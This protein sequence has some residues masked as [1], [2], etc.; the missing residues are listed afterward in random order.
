M[1][2]HTP[3]ARTLLALS[4]TAL[5][6]AIAGCAGGPSRSG[7]AAR[8]ADGFG[9]QARVAVLL[10]ES[11]RFAG[12]AEAVKAGILAAHGVGRQGARPE[13]R[14]YDSS[15]PAAVPGLLRQA[16][17]DGATFAIGPLQKDSVA[18]LAE[19]GT[20]PIPTL[21]LNRANVASLPP[22]LY[23][24]ALS[25][26][27]E[28]EE[29]ANSAWQQGLR[30]ALMLH[31]SGSWGERIASAFRQR[32]TA[33]GG[34]LIAARTYSPTTGSYTSAVTGLF[35][36]PGAGTAD[37]LFLVA[38]SRIARAIA[39]ELQ[40]AAGGL[41]VYATSHI[42]GGSFDSQYDGPL[43][44]MQ[45][46][47]IPWLLASDPS[48]P[49]SKEQLQIGLADFEGRFTRLYAMGID[50][51]QLAP[52]LEWMATRP[53][54]Y[55]DGKTGRLTLDTRRQVRRELI[56]ARMGSGGPV[57]VAAIAPAPEHLEPAAAGTAAPRIAS[58]RP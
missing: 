10:P 50:A 53:G 34:Q 30:S 6:F 38:T 23:Q 57:R 37:F 7:D 56:L 18:A 33:L 29:V 40:A 17:A 22:S 49:L 31:P 14:F 5:V 3:R 54:A 43:V 48:D 35:G 26:E 36:E 4:L 46:V 25:P 32:W 19:S 52:R 47:D 8:A 27:D 15:D 2:R 39:P 55:V 44:G 24:F 12:P 41:P 9:P 11:G 58:V 1:F 13:L 45:F 21:A 16:A 20:L 51:Y 28:A 42:F